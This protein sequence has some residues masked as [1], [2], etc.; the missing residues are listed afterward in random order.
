MPCAQWGSQLLRHKAT[1]HGP[2]QTV[3]CQAHVCRHTEAVMPGAPL[4][5]CFHSSLHV[6]TRVLQVELGCGLINVQAAPQH[7]TQT[8]LQHINLHST[9]HTAHSRQG[10]S[11]M[12]HDDRT[13]SPAVAHLLPP[14]V[15]QTGQKNPSNTPHCVMEMWS[16]AAIVQVSK[17]QGACT[18]S[19]SECNL[20]CMHCWWGCASHCPGLVGAAS[21]AHRSTACRGCHAVLPAQLQS[22]A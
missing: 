21:Q 16:I 18:F 13:R 2:T 4:T 19:L 11:I 5:K 14:A 12:D 20:P 22:P 10:T 6:P 3:T 9:Q 1:W 8:R 7:L 15:R 17:Q